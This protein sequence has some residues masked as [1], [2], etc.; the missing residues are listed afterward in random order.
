MVTRNNITGDKIQTKPSTDCYRNNYDRIFNRGDVEA[1]EVIGVDM[2]EGEEQGV[3]LEIET[4][5]ELF[6]LPLVLDKSMPPYLMELHNDGEPIATIAPDGT[7]TIHQ[8][9][10]DKEAAKIFWSSMELEG[11][12]LHMKI[13]ELTAENVILRDKNEKLEEHIRKVDPLCQDPEA[14]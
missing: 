5:E 13:A 6:G 4:P 2:A 14:W 10:G 11:N 12:N 9:G 7:V 3:T 8:E 1:P